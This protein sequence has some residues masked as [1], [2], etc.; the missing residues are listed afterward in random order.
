MR[1]LYSCVCC[2]WL[3]TF[4]SAFQFEQEGPLCE[5]CVQRPAA[6]QSAPSE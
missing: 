4:A 5:N 2:G 1:P 3:S 6:V